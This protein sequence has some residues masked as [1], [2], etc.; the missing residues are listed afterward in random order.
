MSELGLA[1]EEGPPPGRHRHRRAAAA[2]QRKQKQQQ[3]RGNGGGGGRKPGKGEK[4]GRGGRSLV[5]FLVVVVLLGGLGFAGW[6]GFNWVQDALTTPDYAGEGT[7]AV[8]VEV[9]P[10]QTAAQIAQVLYDADVVASPQAFVEAANANPLSVNIQPGFY[11]LPQQ[12]S[13]ANAVEALLDL[14][15]RIVE[16]VTIREGLSMFRTFDLLSEELDIPVEEF[17]AAAEDPEALGVPD[18]WFNRDDGKD[19]TETVEGFLFPATYE[20]PPDPTAEQVLETMVQQFLTVAD[21]L[22]FVDTVQDE[23]N[24]TPYE[25][26]IVASL[27]EAE[28]GVADDLGR[29]ARVAY[30]RVFLAQMPLQFDVTANYWLEVEGSEPKPSGELSQAELDDPD[31]PFNTV[32]ELGLPAG[33]INSPGRAAMEGAMD[34]PEGGWLY[35]VAIDEEGNSAFAETLGEHELNI[36]EACENGV[37]L[38]CP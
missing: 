1:F 6:W 33:P 11:E 3:G 4:S 9:S 31:N 22:D 35:F 27:A 37:P 17:E 8:T 23:R 15:N 21:D 20:F 32:S 38:D 28:A 5:A 14:T 12:M 19:A 26:L 30:N 24:I 25:A 2:K 7:G 13:A 18:F 10:G 36:Q 16:A 29:V 34:P